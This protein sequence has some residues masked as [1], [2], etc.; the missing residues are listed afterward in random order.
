MVCHVPTPTPA[1]MA[2]PTTDY[3]WKVGDKHKQEEKNFKKK[4]V[5]RSTSLSLSLVVLPLLQ[6]KLR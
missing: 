2:L 3:A 4:E 5:P 1:R 6:F